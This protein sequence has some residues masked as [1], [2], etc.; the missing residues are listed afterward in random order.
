VSDSRPTDAEIIAASLDKPG[1][2]G[3]I[4]DRHHTAIYRFA[5]RR[6]GVNDASDVAGD[7]FYR[8]FTIRHRYD[9][10]KTNCLPWLYGIATNVVGDRLRQLTRRRHAYLVAVW[11]EGTDDTSRDTDD[12]MVAQH[13]GER[14]ND[15]LRR[16]SR[17][18]RDTLLLYALEGLTYSEIAR[19]LG[20]PIGTVGSRISRARRRILELIPDLEQIVSSEVPP[21]DSG[22]EYD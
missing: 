4:F 20:I 1:E 17:K 19:V 21:P 2:F 13:I 12:R 9:V 8:A 18:D 16:L 22:T 10:T 7:V 6:V 5:A 3:R 11:R 15:A 14:L